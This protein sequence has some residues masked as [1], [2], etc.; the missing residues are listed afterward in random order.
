MDQNSKNSLVVWAGTIL[1][2]AGGWWGT[3]RLAA[4]Y[5]VPLGAW[6]VLGGSALGAIAG[7]VLTKM[8]VSDQ[9]AITQIEE[10]DS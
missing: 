4:T 7:A 8:I 6:S 5:A 9:G 3:T 10:A 2:A 1:G